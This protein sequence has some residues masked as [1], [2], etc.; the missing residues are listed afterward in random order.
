MIW[1]KKNAFNAI[2]LLVGI[3]GIMS[4]YYF[5]TISIKVKEPVIVEKSNTQIFSSDFSDTN[6]F[7]LI[8]EST[9]LKV[10][11]SVFFQEVTVWNK[12]KE[13]IRKSDVL[14]PINI[15]Y[16]NDV[17]IIDV[18]IVASTRP[19]IVRASYHKNKN[20]LDLN[21]N[22][23]EQN[24]GFNV[25]V[26]YT[27][28]EKGIAN[29][30]GDIAGVEKFYTFGDLTSDNIFFG[31]G[32]FVMWLFLG[33]VGLFVIAGFMHVCDLLIK[34][35][36]P[37]KHQVITKRIGKVLACIWAGFVVLLLILFVAGKVYQ[38]AESEALESTP[39]MIEV[40]NNETN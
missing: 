13:I 34:R 2:S 36:F 35:I 25:Q 31:V 33:V 12:G 20:S 23:M 29:I 14:S 32:K 22:I 9:G 1:I 7:A 26:L 28:K 11:S 27:S 21:F 5:Y 8:D 19:D 30:S 15:S 3:L 17:K 37:N 38:L 24:D 18:S 16:T 6:R 4:S 10:T 39:N 40:I